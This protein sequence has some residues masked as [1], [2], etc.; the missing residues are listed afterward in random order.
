MA[1]K[2]KQAKSKKPVKAAAK[3]GA[4]PS[5]ESV[6]AAA[7]E[8]MAKVKKG[9]SLEG[10]TVGALVAGRILEGKL[11]TQEIAAEAKKRLKGDTSPAVVYWHRSHMKGLGIAIPQRGA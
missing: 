2:K 9:G 8:A 4:G 6:L 11:S 7:R 3:R 1:A 5:K 10:V